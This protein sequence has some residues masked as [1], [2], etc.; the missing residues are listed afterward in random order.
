[1]I[2]TER[3]GPRILVLSG[4]PEG[5]M[6]VI[7]AEVPEARLI[8]C[9]SYE[10][11][12]EALAEHR[13]E[14]AYVFKIGRAPFPRAALLGAHAPRW[15]QNAGAGMDHLVPWDPDRVIVTNASGA[16]G[17]LMSQYTLWAILNHRL[18]LPTYAR[19]QAE[20]VWRKGEFR[21]VAGCTL[22]IVGFGTIG[23]EI[24]RL[25]KA[26]GLRVIGVRARPE[27]SDHADR[28]V[29]TDD[30]HAALGEADYVSVVLPLTEATR[31]LIDARAIAAIKPG[32]VLVN[33][34]R[35]GIVDEAALLDALNSGHLAGAVL[36]VFASEPLP[37]DHP[38]WDAPNTVILPHISGD[39]ADWK[40]RVTAMFCENLRNWMAGRPLF[41]VVDPAR[42]Y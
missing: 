15:I 22:T 8:P 17:E 11:L 13:P 28:V 12:P 1:M 14:I 4:E 7:R 16:H 26:A 42:G 40:T 20:R 31:G 27:P 6:E 37:P 23:A 30:L 39:P 29:G 10:A 36:D 5:V 34:G 2:E 24:G 9:T 18:G 38:L 35:G 21:S 41:N 32:A 25:A 33:T 19:Q 3:S